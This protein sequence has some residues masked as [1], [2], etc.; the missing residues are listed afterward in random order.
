MLSTKP[1]AAKTTM[2]DYQ[3]QKL[4]LQQKSPARIPL[5]LKDKVSKT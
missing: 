4:Q 5:K 2:E 1:T 3:V